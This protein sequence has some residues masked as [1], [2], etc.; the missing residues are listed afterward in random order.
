VVII[1]LPGRREDGK[2]IIRINL[3]ITDFPFNRPC[4]AESAS[5]EKASKT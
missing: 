4:F 1:I 3:L 2:Y 5:A